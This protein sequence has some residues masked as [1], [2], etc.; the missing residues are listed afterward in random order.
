MTCIRSTS[1]PTAT[2]SPCST[3]PA[4]LVAPPAF[5]V[6]LTWLLLRYPPM[7]VPGP[8][9]PAID[10]AGRVLAR[11]FVTHYR[12]ANPSA[13]LEDLDWYAGLHAARVLIDLAAWRLAGA[14]QADTHPWRLVAPGAATVLERA[15]GVSL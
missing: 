15:S 10:A 12:K 3:G 13:D 1:S 4:R 14:P 8:L 11:R 9:K 2:T 6:A 5:D 7:Q